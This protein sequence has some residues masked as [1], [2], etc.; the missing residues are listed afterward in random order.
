[1]VKNCTHSIFGVLIKGHQIPK[2]TP[3]N[4]LRIS[5]HFSL[6]IK[7]KK[8]F[9]TY[10]NINFLQK[11]LIK[12]Y[13]LS[14]CGAKNLGQVLLIEC[15]SIQWTQTGLETSPH[16][17]PVSTYNSMLIQPKVSTETQVFKL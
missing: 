5:Y 17:S 7:K 15:S 9:T 12:L 13:P 16:S 8:N 6:L 2:M 14:L 4:G 11:K 3:E 1:M 10:G